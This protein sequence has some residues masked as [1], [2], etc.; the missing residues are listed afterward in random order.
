MSFVSGPPLVEVV[1]LPTK[2]Q[3]SVSRSPALMV[4]AK[5]C[6]QIVVILMAVL[7][8]QELAVAAVR[9]L[10]AQ[11]V[12]PSRIII[13]CMFADAEMCKSTL[14]AIGGAVQVSGCY[15]TSY[16]LRLVRLSSAAWR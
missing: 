2:A 13:A 4:F 1:Y 9:A 15:L 7:A 10:Q 5:S 6:G 16:E 12:S 8:D 11:G 3:N 14:R